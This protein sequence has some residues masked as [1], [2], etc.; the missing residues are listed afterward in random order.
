[1]RSPYGL[2]SKVVLIRHPAVRKH[3]TGTRLRQLPSPDDRLRRATLVVS[4]TQETL[5][6][7]TCIVGETLNVP[8]VCA[9]LVDADEQLVMS[10]YGV[11]VSTALLLSHAF[12]KHVV[13]STHVLVVDDGRSDPMVAHNPTVRDGTVR[14][15]VGVPLRTTKGRP[16]GTL[17]AMDRRA[18]RWT[19]SQLDLMASL[20]ILI[21]SEVELGVAVR[22]A[23]QGGVSS[24]SVPVRQG[25]L[26]ERS[27]ANVQPKAGRRAFAR[28][29][30]FD[31]PLETHE[32]STR[33]LD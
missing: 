4:S 30:A 15:C 18:R 5:D 16:V 9:S 2:S 21:V 26:W 12:R 3:P 28:R 22:R 31:Q 6:R 10:S 29:P 23:S 17:L 11:P 33:Y 7:V 20:S 25:F 19:A 14:A 32:S 27:G 8:A 24:K 13:A 1:M